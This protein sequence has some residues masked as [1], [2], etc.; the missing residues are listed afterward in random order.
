MRSRSERG[1][2][3]IEMTFVG[4]PVIFTLI[5]IFEISRGMWMFSTASYA[6]R[7]GTRFAIVHGQNCKFPP[8]TCGT[9]IGAIAIRIRD[10]AV[11][12]PLDTTNVTFT[13]Q[14]A[15]PITCTLNN[16]VTNATV[17][18]PTGGDAA[19]QPVTITVTYPFSSALAMFWPGS[20]PVKFAPTF[21][22]GATST[23]KI[24]F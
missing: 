10:A 14:G 19:N 17:W 23:E 2:A 16:C 13:S 22:F 1:N 8:N 18:P 24:Q 11:G 4:I 5:S 21:T 6:A 12:L 20:A 9:T 15:A 7:E 3:V